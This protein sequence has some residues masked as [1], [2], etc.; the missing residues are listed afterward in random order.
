MQ[1]NKDVLKEC[2]KK[3]K[4]KYV[5]IISRTICQECSDTRKFPPKIRELMEKIKIELER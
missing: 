3:G 1:D 2:M 4:T 5:S